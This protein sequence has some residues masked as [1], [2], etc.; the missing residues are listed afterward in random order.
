MTS[1]AHAIHELRP[2]YPLPILLEVSGMARSSYYYHRIRMKR[3]DKYKRVK[4]LIYKVF[5]KHRRRYGYRRV[6][7]VLQKEGI[8]INHKTVYRLMREMGLVSDL[9]HKKYSSYK[10]ETGKVAPN[11]LARNFHAEKPLEKLVTD[12]TEFHLLGEKIY[13]SPIMDLFNREI[14]SYSIS[15]SPNMKMIDE[16]LE[17]LY[18]TRNIETGT[19]IHSDQGTLYQSSAYQK[20][21]TDRGIVQSMSRKATCLDNAVI[22]NFF[23]ILKSEMFYGKEFESVEQFT[24][25]LKEYLRYYNE[26]RIK[27]NLDGLSPIQYRLIKFVS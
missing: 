3:P 14:L 13:L 8:K 26:D 6:T 24:N 5:N 23:G 20:S 4:D 25:E 1:L 17:G 7:K 18:C 19:I 22:E 27:I 15:S 12:V 9:R 2:F 16:M 10:G 11:I 21:L